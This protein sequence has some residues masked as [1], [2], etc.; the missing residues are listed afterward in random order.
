METKVLSIIG[1]FLV[2]LIALLLGTSRIDGYTSAKSSLSE[3]PYE[4][5][6]AIQSAFEKR[7]AEAFEPKSNEKKYAEAFSPNSDEKKKYAE[8]FEPKSNEKKY[9][10][11][12]E[13]SE[14]API[15]VNGFG[16]LMSGAYGNEKIIGFMYNNDANTTCK[17]YGYTNSKGNICLS[18]SDIKLLTTRGGNAGGAPDQI[19]N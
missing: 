3:Y 11:A 7:Y 13:A 14:S 18:D 5:F 19:G 6:E 9:A 8:A 17:S 2:I 10:E 16:G 1:L 12:F 4:G 15:K